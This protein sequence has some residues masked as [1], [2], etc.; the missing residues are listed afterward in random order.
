MNI[1]AQ[2]MLLAN[3][4]DHLINSILSMEPVQAAS[5]RIE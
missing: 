2:K 1:Y 5:S 4:A 3:R